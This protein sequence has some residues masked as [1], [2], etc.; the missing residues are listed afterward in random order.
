MHAGSRAS[1]RSAVFLGIGDQPCLPPE[2]LAE[3]LHR[4]LDAP[5]AKPLPSSTSSRRGLGQKAANLRANDKQ[6][7]SAS[8][9]S[10]RQIWSGVEF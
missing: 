10:Q 5:T 1:C 4:Q 8:H 9:G 3:P 7:E 6:G 2:T